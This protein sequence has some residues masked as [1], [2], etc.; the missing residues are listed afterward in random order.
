MKY[1]LDTSVI[2]E[3][4]KPV[5]HE[6]VIAW[7][8]DISSEMLYLSVITVGEI[9]KG[10]TRLPD[11]KK[12]QKLVLWLNTILEEYKERIIPI[13]LMVADTWGIMQGN[14]EKSGLPISSIDGLIAA[15]TYTYNLT[16]ITRN[17][18]D[19]TSSKIPTINP[20]K[21]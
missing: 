7:I 3:F 5:P 6:K 1:L 10:I 20:W 8:K 14:A 17:E 4:V 16:L 12:K 11:S 18:D 19:F 2:S 15:T 13:D 9:R 21:L